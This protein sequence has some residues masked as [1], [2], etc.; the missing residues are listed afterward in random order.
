MLNCKKLT[1][2]V[3]LPKIKPKNL[4]Q[5]NFNKKNRDFSRSF[6]KIKENFAM[7][8]SLKMEDGK[9]KIEMNFSRLC[10]SIFGGE[11]GFR[12]FEK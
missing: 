4:G 6:Y 1:K 3:L 7:T 12:R 10:Y 2:E 9:R 8:K 5:S 11:G